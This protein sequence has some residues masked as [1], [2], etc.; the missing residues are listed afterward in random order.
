MDIF[1][2]YILEIPVTLLGRILGIFMFL[3]CLSR[4]FVGGNIALAFV[5]VL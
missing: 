3:F 4:S 2:A 1:Y 5:N